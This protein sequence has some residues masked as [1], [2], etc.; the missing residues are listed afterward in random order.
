MKQNPAHNFRSRSVSANSSVHFSKHIL[1]VHGN[2]DGFT[3]KPTWWDGYF[4]WKQQS[5][6]F[7]SFIRDYVLCFRISLSEMPARRREWSAGYP[8]EVRARKEYIIGERREHPSCLQVWVVVSAY[9]VRFC[10]VWAKT[11]LFAKMS[12]DEVTVQ[13]SNCYAL[14]W[15]IIDE[16]E[17]LSHLFSVVIISGWAW[18][19]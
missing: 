10:N 19:L 11:G 1:C 8:W 4:V 6:C 5:H 7:F 2:Q 18:T 13:W 12:V 15:I 16:Y 17:P 9:L 14:K 3:K